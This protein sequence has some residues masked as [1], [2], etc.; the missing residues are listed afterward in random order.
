MFRF[1]IEKPNDGSVG[2]NEARA[3]DRDTV[4]FFPPVKEL[5]HVGPCELALAFLKYPGF[6]VVGI[7]QPVYSG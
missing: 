2:I 6:P 7:C 1:H 5:Y 3:S 4:N